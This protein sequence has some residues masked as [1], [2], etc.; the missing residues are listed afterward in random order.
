MLVLLYIDVYFLLV[1]LLFLLV[2]HLSICMGITIMITT[3][4]LGGL[5]N[6][7]NQAYRIN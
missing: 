6:Y 7:L 5:I 2:S 4:A 3:H 1:I